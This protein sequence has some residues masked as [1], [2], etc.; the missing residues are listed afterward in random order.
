MG[1]Q[2]GVEVLH[3]AR[4]VGARAIGDGLDFLIL[5]VVLVLVLIDDDMGTV[6]EGAGGGL[7]GQVTL[8]ASLGLREK[9]LD[10]LEQGA[11]RAPQ[12]VTELLNDF[13]L[14]SGRVLFFVFVGLTDVRTV[15]REEIE[16]P[17]LV[18]E[19]A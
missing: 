13:D 2:F 11:F 7:V 4:L 5:L 9:G 6:V 17:V 19:L 8:S 10:K 3:G 12:R 14:S 18:L 1:L 15:P 16:L